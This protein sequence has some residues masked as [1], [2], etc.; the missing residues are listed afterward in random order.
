[1]DERARPRLASHNPDLVAS[2]A[3][4]RREAPASELRSFGV[5][6]G[7]V[8]SFWAWMRWRHGH[9]PAGWLAAGSVAASLGLLAPRALGPFYT[10]WMAV[11]GVLGRINLRI[12]TALLYY[13]VMTPYALFF[14]ALGKDLL[15]LKLRTADSYW[16][17]REPRTDPARYER[18]F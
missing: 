6:L 14:R 10:R 15:D 1:M 13:G 9:S 17:K 5:G 16:R 18:Q 11:V 3:E 2:E 4:G 7:I 8:L 12:L